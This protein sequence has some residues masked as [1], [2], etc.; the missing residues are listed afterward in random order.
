MAQY[1]E[2][3]KMSFGADR[4][5]ALK[6]ARR[7]VEASY[8]LK[9]KC[10]MRFES[11]VYKHGQDHTRRGRSPAEKE[12]AMVAAVN[13]IKAEARAA[14]EAAEAL[15]EAAEAAKSGARRRE[16]KRE[17]EAEMKAR[18]PKRRLRL[19]RRGQG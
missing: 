17:F 12:R 4:D 7:L 1:E 11:L 13:A 19:R 3:T 15:K 16:R 2:A 8:Q 14:A 9:V 18:K 5:L 10:E 6:E